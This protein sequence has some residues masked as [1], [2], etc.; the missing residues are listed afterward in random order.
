MKFS[1]LVA[2]QEEKGREGAEITLGH[3][4]ATFQ[5]NSKSRFMSK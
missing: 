1:G 2:N 3:E 4:T 5:F